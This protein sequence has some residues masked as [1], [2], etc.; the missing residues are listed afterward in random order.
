MKVYLIRESLKNVQNTR[1]GSKA[2]KDPT[3]AAD[4]M[5]MH[6]NDAEWK[7]K[8]LMDCGQHLQHA[9]DKDQN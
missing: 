1:V 7:S 9:A 2:L 8:K 4:E 6:Q 5:D 3:A